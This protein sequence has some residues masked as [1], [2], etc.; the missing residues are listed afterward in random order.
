LHSFRHLDLLLLKLLL[1]ALK[2]VHAP[3]D[4]ANAAWRHRSF[5]LS[6]GV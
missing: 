2:T 1:L 5:D 6:G 4:P 3:S